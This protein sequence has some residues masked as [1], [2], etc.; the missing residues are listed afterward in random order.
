M[1]PIGGVTTLINILISGTELPKTAA[2]EHAGFKAASALT[3]LP[4]DRSSPR[5]ANFQRVLADPK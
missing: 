3:S 1:R 5:N 2:A 4:G